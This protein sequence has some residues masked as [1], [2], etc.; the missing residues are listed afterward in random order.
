LIRNQNHNSKKN[1]FKLR[2]Q[3]LLVQILPDTAVASV[4]FRVVDDAVASHLVLCV[5]VV[6]TVLRCRDYFVR[7]H[8]THYF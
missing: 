6:P 3:I 7:V 2:F 4:R 1:D 5:D 8:S